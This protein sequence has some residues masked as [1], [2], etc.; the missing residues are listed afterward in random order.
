MKIR[1]TLLM[2]CVL[3]NSYYEDHLSASFPFGSYTQVFIAPEMIVSAWSLG[4]SMS[5]FSS[6]LLFDEKLID[7]VC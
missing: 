6:H 1:M 7:Q 4:A 5:I 2:P 3:I